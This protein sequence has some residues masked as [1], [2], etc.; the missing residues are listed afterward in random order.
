MY[1]GMSPANYGGFRSHS[2]SLSSHTRSSF[3]THSPPFSIVSPCRHDQIHI[4]GDIIATSLIFRTVLTV[5]V[6][7]YLK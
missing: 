4:V 2:D 6:A 3:N 5:P 1:E 7:L